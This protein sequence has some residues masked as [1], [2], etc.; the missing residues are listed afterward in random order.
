MRK[1]KASQ[2]AEAAG[3]SPATV[4]RVLNRRGGVS[5]EKEKCVLEWAQ[6]LG[7]D[8]NLKRRPTRT[9]R[10]GV[11]M[12]HPTNPFYES[13]RQA[14]A[15]ANRLFFPSNVQ[16]SIAYADGLAPK[17]AAAVIRESAVASDALVVTMPSHPAINETL[18]ATAEA[19][20]LVTMVTDLPAINRLA[21]V[22]LDNTASG[23]VAGD[24]MGR[25]IGRAGGDVVVVTDMRSM[26]ALQEREQGFA[27]VVAA[28]HPTCR[29]VDV[30]DTLGQRAAAAELVREQIDRH[31][32]LAGIYVTSTGNRAISD[33]LVSRGLDQSTVI[34]THELTTERR[35]LLNRGIIDA[36]IDQNPRARGL[37]RSRNSRPIISAGSTSRRAGWCALHALSARERLKA[38]DRRRYA[39]TL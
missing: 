12:G 20:P 4:D 17:A 37:H 10:I 25:F 11:V 19:K 32:P 3:V 14:F 15:R 13:L 5:A 36:I 33:M 6:K 26:V 27:S 9:L 35:A 30:L 39:A 21:Y 23:R 34:I 1:T 24:L 28:R 2:V 7:L 8:R 38:A 29:L 16:I 18:R 22:G 31:G